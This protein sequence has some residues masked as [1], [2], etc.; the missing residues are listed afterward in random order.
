MILG[1]RI[2]LRTA[3]SRGPCRQQ[4]PILIDFHVVVEVTPNLRFTN[5]LLTQLT[6][7]DAI[8]VIA[9]P[10]HEDDLMGRIQRLQADEWRILWLP[11]QGA[12]DGAQEGSAEADRM[13]PCVPSAETGTVLAAVKHACGAASRLRRC[14]PQCL[15][16]AARGSRQSLH[17]ISAC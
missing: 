15:T 6:P 8:I 9:T 12:L 14:A 11:E 13:K 7:D 4:P 16:A 3:I 17:R 2:R 10:F 5:D 1:T